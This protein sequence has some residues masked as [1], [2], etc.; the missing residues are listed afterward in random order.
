MKTFEE[1]RG[2]MYDGC[3]HL[4][5]YSQEWGESERPPDCKLWVDKQCEEK[6]CGLYYTY[7][8]VSKD[9]DGNRWGREGK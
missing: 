9:R 5:E 1:F 3:P 2:D 6:R 7:K 4:K 8:Q